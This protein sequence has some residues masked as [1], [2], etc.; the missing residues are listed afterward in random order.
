[1]IIVG[2]KISGIRVRV[3]SC[4]ESCCIGGGFFVGCESA[5]SGSF[6]ARWLCL[7]KFVLA[8]FPRF[9][10]LHHDLHSRHSVRS[11]ATLSLIP[12]GSLIA[13]AQ[14]IEDSG[15]ICWRIPLCF[16]SSWDCRWLRSPSRN[17]RCWWRRPAGFPEQRAQAQGGP[18]IHK[19]VCTIFAPCTAQERGRTS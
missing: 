13:S 7:S 11:S 18:H 1:M 8:L 14:I 5:A 15:K 4:S 9:R 10:L 3:R 17:R 12:R 16:S 2:S 6:A 19:R